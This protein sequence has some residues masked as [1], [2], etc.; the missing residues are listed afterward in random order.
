M[1]TNMDEKLQIS[2]AWYDQDADIPFIEFDVAFRLTHLDRGLSFDDVQDLFDLLSDGEVVP[3]EIC[4]DQ[5]DLHAM[6]FITSAKANLLLDGSTVESDFRDFIISIIDD[7]GYDSEE[8]AYQYRGVNIWL[9][10]L[11]L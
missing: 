9:S 2:A 10:D 1:F 4:S 3:L 5:F 7:P 11:H 8:S 6:G